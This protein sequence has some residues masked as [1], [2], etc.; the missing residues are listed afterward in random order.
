MTTGPMTIV[1][2][3]HDPARGEYH[4]RYTIIRGGR[5][6]QT[7]VQLLNHTRHTDSRQPPISR[8]PA[9]L[10]YLTTWNRTSIMG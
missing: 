2:A 8:E 7:S 10:S 1:S 9:S 5:Y 3:D 4:A 6:D